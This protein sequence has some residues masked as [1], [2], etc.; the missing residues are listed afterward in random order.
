M[1]IALYHPF[2]DIEDGSLIKTAA[3]YWDELQTIVPRSIRH[4][5]HANASQEAER[6]GFLKPRF[7][8]S[9]DDVVIRAGRE[10]FEDVEDNREFG[11]RFAQLVNGAIDEI[12]EIN[13]H[14]PIHE[15]K[16]L[17][18]YLEKVSW[19]LQE[20]F[21]HREIGEHLIV[22]GIIGWAYMSRLASVIAQ[23]DGLAPLTNL[24]IF[25]ETLLD[26]FIDYGQE[27]EE[28]QSQL[29]KL[30]MQMVS[31]DPNVPL[32]KILRFRDEHR[33]MLLHFRRCMREFTLQIAAGLATA[34]RQRVLEEIVRDRIVPVKEEIEARLR[35]RR[36]AFGFSFLDI[37]Q[38]TAFGVIGAGGVN[39]LTAIA[40]SLVSLT[41]SLVRS[42][43]EDR[44]IIEGHPLGYLYR[45]QSE[46]GARE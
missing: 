26:R 25:N 43:R 19:W 4:P 17:P 16:W 13:R 39:I 20:V 15:Q 44:N 41:I 24:P 7:V 14:L 35:E 18:I 1:E 32:N 27:R 2:M 11:L 22:P 10:F 21:P 29:V 40:A 28:N 36:I 3:L 9:N 46:F 42:F 37:A 30:S 31:I 38:A 12:P 23:Q 8:H 6:E 34:E 5:Y 45:V 33:D